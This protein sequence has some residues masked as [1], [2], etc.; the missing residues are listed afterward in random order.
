MA[1]KKKDDATG[2][3][4][5]KKGGLD[6]KKI[7]IAGVVGFVLYTK[8]LAGGGGEAE[9]AVTTL[10]EPVEGIVLDAGEVRVSLADEDPHFALVKMGVV[11]EE[12][13]DPLM[14]EPKL[15]LLKDAAIDE[16]SSFNADQLKGERG[17]SRLRDALTSRAEELYN[18]EGE[19]VRV[20]RVVIT[21][22]IVQ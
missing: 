4:E 5:K 18:V 7:A 12:A 19:Q 2:D 6:I 17:A 8:V 11:L 14:L 1:K 20:M 3:D 16:I 9:A 21:E 10:P 13:A 22:L 15:A